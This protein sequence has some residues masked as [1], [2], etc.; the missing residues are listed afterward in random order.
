MTDDCPTDTDMVAE[1]CRRA[2]ELLPDVLRGHLKDDA[3]LPPFSRLID[4]KLLPV[5]FVYIILLL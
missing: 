1:I 3:S 4:E 5:P 2:Y